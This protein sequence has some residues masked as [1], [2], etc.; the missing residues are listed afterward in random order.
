LKLGQRKLVYSA[1]ISGRDES[2]PSL[3]PVS[4]AT[5]QQLDPDRPSRGN[6]DVIEWL[7]AEAPA[8]KNRIVELNLGREARMKV[9]GHTGGNWRWQRT[10][11]LLSAS[12]FQWLRALTE[13]WNR[14]GF[15]PTPS[16]NPCTPETTP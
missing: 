13:S 15:L 6:L 1:A 11:G 10:K 7:E 14:S 2:D 16:S 8:L 4:G 5:L 3:A 12:A 9:L